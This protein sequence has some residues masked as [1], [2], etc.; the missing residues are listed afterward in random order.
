MQLSDRYDRNIRLFGAEGQQKLRGTEVAVIGGG[1]LGSAICQHLAL[2]GVG[3]ITVV[4]DE[5]LDNTNRNRFIGARADDPVPGTHKVEVIERLVR[6][7][8][9]DVVFT[10]NHC[11]L[12]TPEAFSAIRK[13]NWIIGCLDEDG[14]RAILAEVCAAYAKPYI[15]AASDVPEAGIYGGRVC[16]AIGDGCLFCLNQLNQ[17]DVR[18]FLATDEEQKKEAAIY[19]VPLG[20]LGEAGPAVSPINGVVAS[21]AAMELMVAVTGL[22]TP[23]RLLEF[24]GDLSKVFVNHDKPAPDCYYCKGIWGAS[25]KVDVERYL[26]MPH[27]LQRRRK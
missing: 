18:Q 25:E 17:G 2:L 5:Y 16:V 19:G 9:P 14:P 11:S 12:F 4:E 24:R 10:G 22:R 26:R 27:L 6:E 21:L 13:A 8:N 20:A 7:T 3:E 23:S 15:D 1:G